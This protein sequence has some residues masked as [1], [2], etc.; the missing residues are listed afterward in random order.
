MFIALS[1]HNPVFVAIVSVLNPSF[2]NPILIITVDVSLIQVCLVVFCPVG[3]ISVSFIFYKKLYL[4]NKRVEVNGYN[5]L[6]KGP[7][8]NVGAIYA[9]IQCYMKFQI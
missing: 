2:C 1:D 5:I 8:F 7:E 3:S 9:V 6:L 4:T